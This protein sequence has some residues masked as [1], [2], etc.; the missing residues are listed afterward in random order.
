MAARRLLM[1]LLFTLVL[2]QRSVAAQ[3]IRSVV[4][5]DG[6]AGE[7]VDEFLDDLFVDGDDEQDDLEALLGDDLDQEGDRSGSRLLRVGGR[8]PD[9][10]DADYPADGGDP[11]PPLSLEELLGEEVGDAETLDCDDTIDLI[12]AS[13]MALY[14][15]T[16]T[17][18]VPDVEHFG[19]L[20]VPR[21]RK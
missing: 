2:V 1:L 12:Q 20:V 17:R 4:Q 21:G 19:V 18:K 13:E 5:P 6:R 16:D 14:D 3:R 9:Y 8:D 7:D 15:I 11:G 10:D